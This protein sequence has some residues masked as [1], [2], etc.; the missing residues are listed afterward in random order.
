VKEKLKENVPNEYLA[1]AETWEQATK[2][3]KP[4]TKRLRRTMEREVFHSLKKGLSREEI[5]TQLTSK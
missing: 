4:I 5:L 2:I 3:A 1:Q